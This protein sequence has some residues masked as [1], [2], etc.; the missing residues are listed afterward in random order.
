MQ[1]F[2][3]KLRALRR[4]QRMTLAEFAVALGFTSP[5]YM[6]ELETGKQKPSL[7]F[8]IK[9]SRRFNVS[10]DQLSKDELQLDL[11]PEATDDSCKRGTI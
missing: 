8:V 7:E 1:R 10:M 5:S 3:E 2:G 9:V 4:S 6:S 11:P